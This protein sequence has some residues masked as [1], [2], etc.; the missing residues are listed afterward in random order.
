MKSRRNLPDL[1]SD[2]EDDSST[3]EGYDAFKI[4]RLQKTQRVAWGEEDS[5][6]EEKLFEL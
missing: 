1:E 3:T 6:S 4:H 5:D 2:D